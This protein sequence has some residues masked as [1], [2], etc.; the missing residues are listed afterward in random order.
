MNYYVSIGKL[1]RNHSH[2]ANKAACLSHALN[3][4]NVSA[5]TSVTV[6]QQYMM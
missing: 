6:Y 4:P 1:N 3:S 2:S 5:Y